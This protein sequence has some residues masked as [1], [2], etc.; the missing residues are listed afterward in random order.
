MDIVYS[1]LIHSRSF[2]MFAANVT[3]Y[4]MLSELV[5][6]KESAVLF[7][8][9]AGILHVKREYSNGHAMTLSLS[10]KNDRWRCRKSICRTEVGLRK[11][12]WMEGTKIALDTFVHFV[13]W[14]SKEKTSIKFCNEELGMW[15]NL[16]VDN[17]N[18]LREVCGQVLLEDPVQIGT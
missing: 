14:W 16:I 6:D 18:Y 3:S 2:G 17:S 13:Y 8:Q 10:D 7:L 1:I 15:N 5:S 11:G 9:N 4:R 12:T